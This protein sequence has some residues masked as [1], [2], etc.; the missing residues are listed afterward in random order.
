MAALGTDRLRL[1]GER[2]EA[3]LPLAVGLVPEGLRE[4]RRGLIYLCYDLGHGLAEA[5][6]LLGQELRS[7]LPAAVLALGLAWFL[8]HRYLG[9]PLQI[10]EAHTQE[11]A[12]G[13]FR[14]APVRG[15]GELARLARAF[16]EMGER[17]ERTLARLRREE[18]RYRGVLQ[19]LQDGVFLARD[20]R[21][22]DANEAFFRILG[23]PREEV[24]GR[25]IGSFSPPEQP[26]GA[27]SLERAQRLVR[28]VME[29]RPA[30]LAWTVQR[31]DGALV[32]VEVNAARLD[33]AGE[34]HLMASV[35]DVT[36]RRRAERERQRLL[37]ELREKE[38]L[39]RLSNRAGRIGT[40]EWDLDSGR[41]RW[42]EGIEAIYGLPPGSL[43][44]RYEHD[45]QAVHPQD[46]ARVEEAVRAALEGGRPLEVEHRVRRADA[47]DGW[48]LVRGEVVRD[49]E[50]RPRRLRGTVQDVTER[51]RIQEEVERLAYY[52]PLSGLANR[53]LLLDRLRQALARLQREGLGGAVLFIDL[54]RFKP[55]NDALG[56]RAG[57]RVCRRPPAASRPCSGRWTRWRGS[58]GTS[59]WSCS[60]PWAGSPGRRPGGRCGRPSASVPP[61]R[62]ATWW[63]GTAS[64]SG[65]ASGW[66][67]SPRT[68]P[69]RRSSCT[70]PTRPCTG[71]RPAG[72]EVSPSTTPASRRRRTSAWPWSRACGRPWRERGR[73]ARACTCTISSKWTA[74]GG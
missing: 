74:R 35:R 32:E 21:Y 45:R 20:G 23:R 24:L 73:A 16:T 34:P 14:P 42:S 70:T 30:F 67:S 59:S 46:R 56:H 53:R 69:A 51:R 9:R 31:P 64:T 60:R 54:D 10:L 28:R 72:G 48:M 62:R 17:L 11:L 58:A 1:R 19:A 44:G 68:A 25:P 49:A 5:R 61:S 8:L 2:L 6:A 71:P 55:L 50:G 4:P 47:T 63:T 39:L 29:G 12:T 52:D 40:W 22:V 66:P 18:A 65:P 36:E 41:V 13:R 38:E 7:L 3:Y 43:V 27:L 57:D 33:L 15:E 37:E 26:D